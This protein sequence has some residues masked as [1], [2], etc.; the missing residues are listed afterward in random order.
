VD[1]RDEA[2]RSAIPAL[3]R[4]EELRALDPD[5][6]SYGARAVAP[7][8]LDQARRLIGAVE[9]SYSGQ[10]SAE[11]DFI[12]PVANGG[13]QIEWCG[14]RGQLELEIGPGGEIG[15]LVVRPEAGAERYEERHGVPFAEAVSMVARALVA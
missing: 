12:A 10:G 8:A 14:P 11:P 7:I 5:W 3:V 6:D 13:L 15:Y 9:E 1:G 2:G 4:L